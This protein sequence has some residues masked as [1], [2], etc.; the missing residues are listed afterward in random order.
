MEVGVERADAAR[1]LLAGDGQVLEDP[2]ASSSGD[3]VRLTVSRKAALPGN[4]RDELQGLDGGSRVWESAPVYLVQSGEALFSSAAEMVDLARE[5]GLSLGQLALACETELL[6]MSEVEVLEETL[7]RYDIMARSVE[8]GLE[9]DFT[10]MQL[11]PPCAGAVF[12]AE[13]EGRLSVRSLHTRAAARA[14][15][16]MHVDAA[17]GVVCAAPTGGSAGVIPGTLVTLAEERSL[18]REQLGRALLAAG[19]IGRI[20]AIRGT[21]AAEVAGVPGGDRSVRGDGGRCG[22]RRRRRHCPIGLRC[23]RDCVP[24]HHGE[25]LRPSSRHG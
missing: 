20:L 7:R 9:S 14:M 6:G 5:R 16:V 4:F 19:A 12:Q 2:V 21:F 15:A 18:T 3:L 22:R 10:G 1:G 8:R 11:L 13:A 17:M 24:E 25:R 23:G